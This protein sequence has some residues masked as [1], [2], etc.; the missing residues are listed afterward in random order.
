[1]FLQ[2]LLSVFGLNLSMFLQ[3]LAKSM[4]PC[5]AF[6]LILASRTPRSFSLGSRAFSKNFLSVFDNIIN[7]LSTYLLI[8][9]RRGHGSTNKIG[10][11]GSILSPL[12]M[13]TMRHNALLTYF[14]STSYSYRGNRGIFPK[15]VQNGS[16]LGFLENLLRIEK[17][18][19]GVN[20]GKMYHDCQ[21][22][23]Q[24]DPRAVIFL[25]P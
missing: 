6:F 10:S 9:S 4:N 15:M 14:S 24:I 2:E 8:C 5:S 3:M 20:W 25:F 12:V 21:K 1:M 13:S 23:L 7:H 11:I 19:F 17:K 22:R 18:F 16:F